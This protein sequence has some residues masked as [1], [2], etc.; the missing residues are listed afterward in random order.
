MRNDLSIIS[1]ENLVGVEFEWA[2]HVT[3]MAKLRRF[4]I[5][6][7]L[8]THKLQLLQ[9][10]WEKKVTTA[11]E[12]YDKIIDF[13]SLFYSWMSYKEIL[14]LLSIIIKFFF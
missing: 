11:F 1:G 12:V 7:D 2:R 6:F 5:N 13:I 8:K 14:D 10:L 3:K 4:I 9:K